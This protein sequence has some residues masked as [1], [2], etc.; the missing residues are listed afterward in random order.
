MDF[1]DMPSVGLQEEECHCAKDEVVSG[2]FRPS[3]KTTMCLSQN[4]ESGMVQTDNCNGEPEQDWYFDGSH[5]K[6]KLDDRCLDFDHVGVLGLTFVHD[7]HD[8]DNQQWQFDGKVL[9]TRNGEN[10]LDYV[11]EK[12]QVAAVPMH[13]LNNM[14]Y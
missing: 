7:C 4:L 14:P 12:D 2:P 8:G 5:M 11:D 6:S 1:P 3:S 10:C 13:H 9:K